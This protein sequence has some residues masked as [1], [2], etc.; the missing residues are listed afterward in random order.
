MATFSTSGSFKVNNSGEGV[1]RGWGGGG[2]KGGEGMRHVGGGIKV[3]ISLYSYKGV[4]SFQVVEC[5]YART[6]ESM[7]LSMH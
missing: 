3:C 1:G 5:T 4:G 2:E 6:K 7:P